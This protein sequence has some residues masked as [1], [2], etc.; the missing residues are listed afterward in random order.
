MVTEQPVTQPISTFDIEALQTLADAL[1]ALRAADT[2]ALHAQAPGTA[3]QS[4]DDAFRVALTVV[5]GVQL[6]RNDIYNRV[7]YGGAVVQAALD[8]LHAQ[9]VLEIATCHSP[10]EIKSWF[11]AAMSDFN[12]NRWAASVFSAAYSLASQ[13]ATR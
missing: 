12:R 5:G 7:V 2:S 9:E 11:D 6:F 1:V 13:L 8:D 4:V 3:L 10:A